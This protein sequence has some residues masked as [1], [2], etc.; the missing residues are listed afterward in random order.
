MVSYG[1]T[2]ACDCGRVS[3]SG[4]ASPDEALWRAAHLTR[5]PALK[6]RKVLTPDQRERLLKIARQKLFN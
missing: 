5:L 4:C 1:Q 3:V 2:L 6:L